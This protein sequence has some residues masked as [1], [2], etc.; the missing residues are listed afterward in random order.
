MPE[1]LVARINA[2]LTAE[3][4]QRTARASGASVTPLLPT[5]HRRRARLLLAMAGAA[6]A[7]VLVAA[8]GTSM[9]TTGQLST[10]GDSAAVAG[11]S[12]DQESR[13]LT[14]PKA[15]DKAGALAERATTPAVVRIGRSGTRY[16]RADFATQARVLRSAPLSLV[17]PGA[18]GTSG[19]G[20][21]GTTGG[22]TDCLSAIGA[23]RAQVVRADIAFYEGRPAV[24]IVA[25]TN[26]VSLAYAV[27]PE[28]SHT[29]AAVLRPATP[30]P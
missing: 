9:F 11:A 24:V 4:A 25:T 20:P 30:L 29:D 15:A 22:L 27:G 19:V 13:S 5:R 28:C 10:T 14:P 16:I 2:S 26:G 3:Q 21:A 1:H 12:R 23:G 18:E 17:Q 6:A 8:V 7:V